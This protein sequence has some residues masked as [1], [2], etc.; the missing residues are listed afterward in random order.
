MCIQHES[1]CCVLADVAAFNDCDKP[2]PRFSFFLPPAL[3]PVQRACECHGNK[4]ISHGVRPCPRRFHHPSPV[5]LPMELY[6]LKCIM[7]IIYHPER[8]LPLDGLQ[9]EP[10]RLAKI[11]R[12]GRGRR[13]NPRMEDGWY[14]TAFAFHSSL[15]APP[16]NPSLFNRLEKQDLVPRLSRRARATVTNER[17]IASMLP[18][19]AMSCTSYHLT[20]IPAHSVRLLLGWSAKLPELVLGTSC[21]RKMKD[22]F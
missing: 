8:K 15:V 7:K 18:F 16:A 12:H 19:W 21:P 20:M 9:L 1:R 22:C 14:S 11:Q 10:V 3:H 5:T 6:L 17:T 13:R 4:T 2:F